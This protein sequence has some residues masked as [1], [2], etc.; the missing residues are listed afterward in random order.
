VGGIYDEVRTLTMDWKTHI[1]IAM[2]ALARGLI[3]QRTFAETMIEVGLRAEDSTSDVWLQPGRLTQ[4]DLSTVL[5]T[6]R[7]GH[8]SVTRE[9]KK[10][11]KLGEGGSPSA[12]PSRAPEGGP[13]KEQLGRA[14]TQRSADGM[15]LAPLEGQRYVRVGLL[16]SGGMGDVEECED[17]LLKRR[18]AL[19][20]IRPGLPEAETA[21]TLLE[22]E[23]Q[24]TGA[25]EHPNIIPVYD[26]GHDPARGPFYVMRVVGQSSLA[27]V[28]EALSRR[29][30]ITLHEYTLGRLLRA[31]A[32]VC[33]AID[34]AH[35]RGVVHRDI[36]PANILLGSFGEVLVV[37]W[38][39]AHWLAEP[40]TMFGG[41]P[42]YIAPEAL[43][44]T[45]PVDVRSDVFA[46]GAVLYEVL[47]Q[48]AAFAHDTAEDLRAAI[49]DP[50]V[51]YKTEPPRDRD[52]PWEVAEEIQEICLK[53]LSIDPA[54]RF[55]TAGEMAIA[56]EAFLEGTKEKERKR[57]RADELCENGDLLFESYR[58][59]VESR[60]SRIAELGNLRNETAP[61]D[62]PESKQ[63]LWDAE[64]GFAVM[65]NLAIRTMQ[66]VV[67]AYE[68]ALEEVPNHEHARLGL[69]RLYAAELRRAEDRRDAFDR[70]YFS[71]RLRQYQ[72]TA[73][74]GEAK[75]TV[76]AGAVEA[77]AMLQR[78]EERHRRL[79]LGEEQLLGVTPLEEVKVEAGSYTVILRRE[80]TR[81]VRYPVLL[82][83][84]DDL[85][86]N[87]DVIAAEDLDEGEVLI[88]GGPA[89]LGGDEST[90]DGRDLREV[91]VHSFI[92]MDK[93]VTFSDYLEFVADVYRSHPRLAESYLPTSDD[94]AVY[95]TWN[96][97]RFVAA[98]ITIWGEDEN[99]L[100][101]LPA[102]GV[103]AWSAEAYANWKSRKTKHLYRLPTQEEWEKAAR[104]VDGRRFPW[105]DTFD[106]SFCKMRES[107]P[108]LPRPEPCGAFPV[109]V[110][111]YGI[112]DMAGGVADWVV[113]AAD[114]GRDDSKIRRMV[115]RGG[116]W[117]DASLDCRL[118]ARR[119]YVA[120]EKSS[121]VGFRLARTVVTR[122]S[123]RKHGGAPPAS[124]GR[125]SV[126]KDMR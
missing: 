9:V 80:G 81:P 106:A 87:V 115:T 102:V 117:S 40:P 119:P 47:C 10:S 97:S 3:D 86:V 23:A 66:S 104:G 69:A 68:G 103:D 32:Q 93:P 58:E 84:D 33:H 91:N 107:R 2:V 109:D 98:K 17:A 36:K 29:H 44:P 78:F 64:D 71:E 118:S 105:G 50:E 35:N 123:I 99:V 15:H 14:V 116:A 48:K 67:A 94:G 56:V 57:K 82:R 1:D 62:P 125:L 75:L 74:G 112:K 96:G 60:P 121:R 122:S 65:E 59:L 25:L 85:R 88:P 77:D 61:W 5:H 101:S 6:V 24:I 49:S 27:H 45:R 26:A 18:V 51:G 76:L 124:V 19:K 31:F 21:V 41:T 120:M 111:P 43:D 37:D 83:P 4:A 12:R 34:Y 63:A 7:Q 54:Q 8:D 42:G 16:G 92:I 72:D 30:E 55:G 79:V 70:V 13:R 53:A 28:L 100:I 39:V 22:R 20:S 89:L 73:S 114:D 38:G 46:L 95:F 126:R 52:P 108:G 110:S 11:I 90:V 113:T